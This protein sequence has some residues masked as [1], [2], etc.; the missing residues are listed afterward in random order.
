MA[1]TISIYNH[2]AKLFANQEVDVDNL[3]VMLIGAGGSFNAAHTAVSS[4]SGNE[5]SGNGWDSGGEPLAGE[6]V[7][8]VT[9]NDAKLDADDV[10]VE[11]TGGSIGPSSFYCLYDATSNKPLLWCEF[12]EPQTATVGNNM[13]IIFNAAGLFTWTVT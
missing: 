1:D 9:T 3:K 13:E 2:T 7:T 6:A 10:V 12:D 4:V 5:V 8:T 11:A